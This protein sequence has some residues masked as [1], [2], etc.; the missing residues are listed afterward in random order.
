MSNLIVII[1]QLDPRVRLRRFSR[2]GRSNLDYRWS[3]VCLS[4]SWTPG[5]SD[6]QATF[7]VSSVGPVRAQASDFSS[8]FTVG[9]TVQSAEEFVESMPSTRLKGTSGPVRDSDS[10]FPQG[11][12][13]S[14]KASWMRVVAV[15]TSLPHSVWM[16]TRPGSRSRATCCLSAENTC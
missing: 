6:C 7:V 13:S 16:E 4:Y 9:L 5:A 10:L 3:R 11:R 2:E 14:V 8:V 15:W 12:R 1:E